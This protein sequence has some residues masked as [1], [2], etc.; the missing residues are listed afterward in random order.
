MEGNGKSVSER[1]ALRCIG[2]MAVDLN[3]GDVA[4]GSVDIA[5][6]LGYPGD[7]IIRKTPASFSESRKF[8]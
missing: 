8:I 2:L 5:D 7:V 6:L 3:I 4:F 1:N